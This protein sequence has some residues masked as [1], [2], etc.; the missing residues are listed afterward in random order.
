MRQ[1]RIFDT[2]LRDGEQAPGCSMDLAEKLEIALALEKMGV[3]VI[4]AGFAIASKGDAQA[5]SEVAR[6]IKHCTV[7]SLARAT[8]QDIDAA[9]DAVRHAA[10]PRIH[11]FL[12]TSPTHME[13]K[14]KMSQEEV[15][16]TISTMVTYAC[17]LCPDVEFSAEDASRSEPVFLAK[18]VEAAIL[19]GAKTINIP[20]TVGYAMPEELGS[21]I[22]FLRKN[23]PGI[24]GVDLACHC[25][26]DLG[27][28]V[29]NTLAAMAAGVTQIECTVN[30]IGERAG[31]AALEEIV[32]ALHTRKDLLQAECRID[33]TKLYPTSRLVYHILGLNAPIN[34]AIVGRNAF[35]HEAGI[36]Q[37][38]VMANRETYEIMTPESVG[39]TQNKMVLGKHSGKHAVERVY[40]QMGYELSQEEMDQLFI[41]FK[42]LCDRK[43][44]ISSQD[45][46]ALI[47]HKAE[48][49]Q[50][51][52]KL[53]KYTV[54][55]GNVVSASAVVRL[56]DGE[57]TVQEIAVGNGPIDAALNAIDKLMPA[58]E[59][60]LVD[61]AIQTISEGKDAQG[62]AILKISYPGG[63]VTGRGLSTDV[64]EAS[65]LAYVNAMNKL[66]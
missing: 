41:R 26:N 28:G 30:G 24:E 35:A 56:F 62:E 21:L 63:T 54:N 48:P 16:K 20:D 49:V 58:G 46:E 3:D 29:A 60:T 25:H 23:V 64:V 61:Y 12:A 22:T 47:S 8:K 50:K 53:D 5:I 45:L 33:T 52:Y 13:Y 42:A 18:A 36:H 19:A 7:A 31:N 34:K 38:G 27:L 6:V 37:H 32:M 59:H 4:E 10:H 1:I 39:L 43:K 9:W 65:L 57:K 15:L 11:T 40:H 51:G 14:L 44:T 55:S 2:T 66:L 17:S